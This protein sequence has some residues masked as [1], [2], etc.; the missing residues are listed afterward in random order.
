MSNSF[1]LEQPPVVAPLVVIL[2]PNEFMAPPP[3][4]TAISSSEDE[5][6]S[7]DEIDPFDLVD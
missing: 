2:N 6:D 4:L 5:Y 3:A 1:E 7:E